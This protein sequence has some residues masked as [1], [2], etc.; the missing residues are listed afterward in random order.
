MPFHYTPIT[1]KSKEVFN[2]NSFFYITIMLGLALLF[3]CVM[4][5]YFYYVKKL[6]AEVQIK[7]L[8]L[9]ILR[10][11]MKEG[12]SDQNKVQ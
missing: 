5:L 7:E 10:L 12:P 8:D 2:L 3:L 11:G 4:F 1:K 9:E 6:D